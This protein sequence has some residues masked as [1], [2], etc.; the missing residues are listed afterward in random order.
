MHDVT[1][2]RSF[3]FWT[4][5]IALVTTAF[6]F[7]LRIQ[8]MP[9]WE[10]AFALD[11]TQA[12]TIFG[13][14]LWPFGVSIV[15]FSLVIDRVGYGKALGFAFVCF[16]LF[17]VLTIF[18][19]GFEMLYW[20][21]VIGALGAGAV[22]AA[23]N[24][25]IATV[26]SDQK[27]KWLNI[28]HAG[29]PG[30]LVVTGIVVLVI[31]DALSWQLKI[32]LILVPSI[33][34]A[35]M[36]L[37]VKFPTSE[38]VL[39]GVSYRAMLSEVGWAGAFIVALMIVMELTSN[40]LGIEQ[41]Q[42]LTAQ[43][44]IAAGIA[45]IYGIYITDDDGNGL[46]AILRSFGRPMYVFLLLV[47]LL[48]ATTELGTDAWVKDLLKPVMQDSIGID[49]GWVLV[50][51]A[52]IMMTLRFCCGPLV[53]TFKPLGTLAISAALAAW[54]I[55]WLSSLSG[56]DATASATVIAIAATIYG[57]GQTFFWPTTLGV[58]SEQFPKGGA[59]TINI[60]AGVGML[61]VGVLGGAWLGN[62]QDR[63]IVA[64]LH[65]QAPSISSRYITDEKQSLFGSYNAL[66]PDAKERAADHLF[67][68]EFTIGDGDDAR[69]ETKT[70]AASEVIERAQRDGKSAALHEVAILPVIM[71]CCYIGL[72]LYFRSRGGYK[73]VLLE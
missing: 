52:G 67:E 55:Y 4:C 31:G 23:I 71:F 42:N 60:I 16:V 62:V 33:V 47:M 41:L 9:T 15:L 53:E 30:G 45:A 38:R 28:L 27:T 1:S 13:A 35:L 26:Y 73:P 10:E 63:S 21:S 69:R 57:V 32:A 64:S 50:Y 18:A 40:V 3:L 58:V 51:T 54:G 17:A 11:K 56:S 70:V 39:A 25:L 68:M 43:V 7:M 59:M 72:M 34:F 2:N 29:W 24:P 49:S 6:A 20:G 36:M 8:L 46:E 66:A 37:R 44:V 12:G 5:F 19:N 48:L 61:G 14:G 22:E 65:E